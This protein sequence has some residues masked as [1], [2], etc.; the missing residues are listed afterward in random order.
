MFIEDLLLPLQRD[1]ADSLDRN[2]ARSILLALLQSID[3]RPLSARDRRLLKATVIDFLT[4]A[5]LRGD[6]IIETRV[7]IQHIFDF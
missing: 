5:N 7:S 3:S 2:E 6:P 1:G 4:L